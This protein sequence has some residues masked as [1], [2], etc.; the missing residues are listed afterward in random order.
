MSETEYKASEW[1]DLGN[2]II[3]RLEEWQAKFEDYYIT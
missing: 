3:F 2:T 1:T